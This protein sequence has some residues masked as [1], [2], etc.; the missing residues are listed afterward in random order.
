MDNLLSQIGRALAPTLSEVAL[1][2]G[3]QVALYRPTSSVSNGGVWRRTYGAPDP[4]WSEAKAFFTPGTDDQASGAAEATLKPF[5][6][7]TSD[8]GS[9]TFIADATGAL[10]DVA[11]GD[12]LK[13][14]T[15]PYTGFTWVAEA[16]S[17]P[18]LMG[19][20]TR[21]QVVSAPDGAIL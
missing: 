5:G 10:P 16:P 12:G 1:G 14:L 3:V 11:F 6:V 7:R 17:V 20:T 9:I 4:A 18:D 13:I 15:G 21:V 8:R 2:F 19:A